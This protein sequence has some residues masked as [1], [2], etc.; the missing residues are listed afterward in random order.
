MAS[1]DTIGDGVMVTKDVQQLAYTYCR[2]GDPVEF[3]IYAGLSHVQAG[4][5][6]LEQAQVFLTQRFEGLPLQ[7]GCNDITP[8]N[9]IA[10][11]PVRT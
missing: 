2:R 8:G 11:V 4:Q 7:S 9:S 3:H 5:P 6:F 10:P 1:P